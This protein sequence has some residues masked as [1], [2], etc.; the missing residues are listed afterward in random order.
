MKAALSAALSVLSAAI[1]VPAFAAPPPPIGWT[2]FYVGLNA[3]Y[4]WGNDTHVAVDAVPFVTIASATGTVT[5]TG[6]AAANSGIPDVRQSGFIGG[7]QFG[8]NYQWRPNVVVGIETDLQG[9][10]IRGS[11]SFSGSGVDHNGNFFRPGVFSPI[12]ILTTTGMGTV[13]GGIDWMG[14]VRG[15]IGYLTRPATL[16]FV[17]GGLTYASVNARLTTAASTTAVTDPA[18][19]PF[20]PQGFQGT[21]VGAGVP[22]SQTSIRAGWNIGGGAEWL[23]KPNWSI[24][25]E[26][27]YYDL[28]SQ[29]VSTTLSGTGALFSTPFTASETSTARVRYNGVVARAGINFRLN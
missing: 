9:S 27:F 10:G 4:G 14:T 15:R 11:G 18:A 24:K 20:I 23:V 3:G 1:A 7:G 19:P 6:I 28:G 21:I 13:T 16:F 26:A 25:A 29:W 12:G 2:G 22:G 5:T 17:T 8:Y